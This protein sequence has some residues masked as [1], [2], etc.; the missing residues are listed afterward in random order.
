MKLKKNQIAFIDACRAAG[1]PSPAKRS[2]LVAVANTMGMKY[3]PGWL[4]QDDKYRA[5]RGWFI[6]PGLED[7]IGEQN[8][9]SF[10]RAMALDAAEKAAAPAPKGTDAP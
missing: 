7:S 3:A 2:D 10:D 6:L 1:L 8:A 5:D 4:V 9:V